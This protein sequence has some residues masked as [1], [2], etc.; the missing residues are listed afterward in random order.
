MKQNIIKKAVIIVFSL[1]W[2][3]GCVVNT[4]GT[5]LSSSTSNPTNDPTSR[6]GSCSQ[7][8][9]FAISQIQGAGHRS[10]YDGEEVYCVTGIVT[11]ID[12]GG[13]YLQSQTPDEDPSTSEG[14]YI[15]MLAFASVKV[16]DE[17][18]I[19]SGEVR[20]YNPAGVGENSLTRTS[21]RAS[22]VDVLSSG[23]ELPAPVLIGDKG[24][25]IPDRVIENDVQGY[26]GQGN[27]L[28]DPEEDGMDF[29]ESLESM[30]VQ[31]DDPV[32]VS[33]INSYN[34]VV[35][36]ADQGKNVSGLSST[37][38]LM[39]AED[40]ANPERILLDDKF[41]RMPQILVGDVFT[42]PIVGI[43]DYD[44]GNYRVLPTEK[45]VIQSNSV[46]DRF[47]DV[48]PTELTESQISVASLNLLNYSNSESPERT[49]GFASMIV[50]KLGSPDILVLQEVMDDDGRLNSEVVR[51][52]ENLNS[53]SEAIEAKG[54]PDY[55]WFNIDP[56]RNADGGVD[57]GNIRIVIMFRLDRGLR[58]LSALPGT[59]DEE[60]GL[61]GEG[62]NLALT[63][64][65]G[66][67]WPNNS[68]FNESR[69]PIVAQFQFY[70]ENFFVIG[71]H[72]N[73]KGPDGP[74]Y[75][76]Q[77]PPELESE[78]QRIAQAKAVN[79]FV[80]DIL[81]RDPQAKILVAG[82]LN[83]FPWSEAI[84]TL[85]ETELT[86]LF[87]SIDRQQWVTFIYEGN[88][89][90]MDQILLSENFLQ[91]LSTFKVINI[92]SILPAGEQLTDHDPVMVVLDFRYY[93]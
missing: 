71:A 51:A 14:I 20:E 70:G 61:T 33:S 38:L 63:K 82:D 39:L 2:L 37:G 17:V 35:V 81:E 64:N 79:G 69:K 8:T 85:A 26:V 11:A 54:G 9:Q 32:A 49:E 42:Q 78:T 46:V 60:V 50:E 80:K 47:L 36:V 19:A 10:P 57:G 24:R 7:S 27:G 31:V 59:A 55:K 34:E 62:L 91:N 41:I 44:F 40:D 76:D 13:F 58:F 12:G 93:E 89:Q 83:D 1:I 68:A 88:A 15:D 53:L 87:D 30:R 29:F 65:P 74:L 92:N 23:N 77:Q 72:F 67:I 66:R 48:S 86:N 73:S 3:S 52:D 90:V 43:V 6:P 5:S 21:L 45:L 22:Q 4:P 25:A 28:F 56:K 75:G 16:G 84:Q 18:L